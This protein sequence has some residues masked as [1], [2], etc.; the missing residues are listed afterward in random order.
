MATS[1]AGARRALCGLVL[2]L[3]VPLVGVPAAAG[4][5]ERLDR[6]DHAKDHVGRQ[7]ERVQGATDRLGARIATLDRRR[8][9]V[10][11][12]VRALNGRLRE[13]DD[14]IGALE[15]RMAAAQR[16]LNALD[17]RLDGISARL[18]ER[19]D[20]Y[21]ARAVSA[22]KA[23]PTAAID[24]L[25][26]SVDLSELLNRAA[27][28]ESA[29]DADSELIDEIEV[30]EQ[31]VATKRAQVEQR[32]DEIASDRRALQE[33]RATVAQLRDDK[34]DALAARQ[35]AIAT[36]K[37]L[38][39]NLRA[40]E[41][42]LQEVESQLARES[43]R[44]EA[45]LASRASSGAVAPSA[46][47]R[48]AWPA[49]GPVT[50]GFGYRTH[51]IFGDRR[52]HTGIDIA[53]GYGAPVWAAASGSVAYAGTM[54]GYGNVIVIDHGGGLATTYNHLSAFLVSPGQRV[55]RGQHI[56]AVGCTG[57][58][59]GPHLHFEVRVN[60]TPVDPMPYLQ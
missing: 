43:S 32:K 19:E 18:A 17:E 34:A 24:T 47:G 22:Y 54:S 60:G 10:E 6:L 12:E 55:A 48:L 42:R 3:L 37:A 8:A 11:G 27:Y 33:H 13:L 36:K 25:L 16:S 45:L 5:R 50:S 4:P 2:V 35:A 20:L 44:I 9:E 14:Q 31:R 29:L 21:S 51:P 49:S 58:C 1:S 7:L 56:G 53:A 46:T 26:S 28:Y 39:A 52:M 23:G 30:L 40:R 15:R 38:F 59:T 57:Y 41:R